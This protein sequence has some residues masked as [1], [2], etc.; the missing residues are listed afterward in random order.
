M[1]VDFYLETKDNYLDKLETLMALLPDS[2]KGFLLAKATSYT[3]STRVRYAEDLLFFFNYITGALPAAEGVPVNRLSNDILNSVT[4]SDIDAYLAYLERYEQDG[5]IYHN[6]KAAQKRK[7]ASLRSFYKFCF[8]RGYTKGNPAA[9]VDSPKLPKNDIIA[10]DEDDRGQVIS[11]LTVGTGLTKT[12]LGH[13]PAKT[14]RDSAIIYLL[15][16]TGIRVSELVGLDLDD[17]DFSRNRASI[18]RKGGKSDHVFFNST[19]A[20]ALKTY[21]EGDRKSVSPVKG[22]ENALF[23]SQKGSRMSVSAVERMVKKYSRTTQFGEKITPHKYRSS[24]ASKTAET[25]PIAAV[26]AAMG[27]ENSSTTTR[28]Y[29]K[30]TD[31]AKKK[32]SE[33]PIE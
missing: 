5:R 29:T 31:E 18:I 20:E 25:N 3:A 17:I 4:A 22:S 30:V 2:A 10:L 6:D 1:A 16:G 33:T 19:V 27:H 9:L 8:A 21:I 24:F 23:I 13:L 15:L 12:E 14:A 26:A 7:L 28:Y 32:V 11:A